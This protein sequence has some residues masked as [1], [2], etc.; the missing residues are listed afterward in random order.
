MRI[1]VRLHLYDGEEHRGTYEREDH[2]EAL[3][4]PAAGDPI[5]IHELRKTVGG[6]VPGTVLYSDH[7]V[8]PADDWE[9]QP[10]AT[11]NVRVNSTL[12]E[13]EDDALRRDGWTPGALDTRVRA[14]DTPSRGTAT[15][16]RNLK[17]DLDDWD[18]S[19]K[20]ATEQQGWSA[21]ALRRV[22][23]L[24]ERMQRR[25]NDETERR[26]R[27]QSQRER[28]ESEQRHEPDRGRNGPAL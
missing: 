19:R 6:P 7:L 11:I 13:G 4:L 21:D 2:F 12:V 20:R 16:T 27:E 8:V 3:A 9:A 17:N 26:K 28:W 25:G 1:G 5:E 15:G 24:N 18:R 23:D 22:T 14:V 10:A